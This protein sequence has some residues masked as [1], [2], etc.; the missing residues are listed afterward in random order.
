MLNGALAR[1]YAQALF[2]LAVEVSLLDQVDAEL[3][4]LTKLIAENSELRHLLNHPNIEAKTK[5]EVLNKIL[6]QNISD[7]TRHFFYLLID[8][9]RQNLTKHIQREFTRLAN[10]ARNV[11]EAQI[12]SAVPLAEAQEEK[13][14]QVIAKA[15]GKNVRLTTSVD[16]TLIGGAKLQI[17]DRVMDGSIATALEKLRNQLK[18]SS[19]KPQQEVGE[20]K[21]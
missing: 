1:R 8:R 2:E 18:K 12:V 19:Y 20:T 5:K 7:I 13:L 4:E 16:S 10:E 17:G 9:R 15:T 6:D 21:E 11:I 14:K 3:Q